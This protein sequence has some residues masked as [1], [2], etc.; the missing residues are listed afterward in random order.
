MYGSYKKRDS[1]SIIKRRAIKDKSIPNVEQAVEEFLAAGGEVT[2]CP[3]VF[4]AAT[5]Q[6][7]SNK[8]WKHFKQQTS[9]RR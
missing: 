6:V 2:K 8:G 1:S 7:R 9:K 5:Q 3:T 4:A